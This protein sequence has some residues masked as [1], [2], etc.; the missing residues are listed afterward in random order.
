MKRLRMLI[1]RKIV[2]IVTLK[3]KRDSNRLE[4]ENEIKPEEKL[5]KII[6]AISAIRMKITPTRIMTPPPPHLH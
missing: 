4:K 3:L 1:S 2:K 5:K 6:S